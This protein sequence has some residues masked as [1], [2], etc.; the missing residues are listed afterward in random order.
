MRNVEWDT[1]DNMQHL[2]SEVFTYNKSGKLLVNNENDANSDLDKVLL[3]RVGRHI[4]T[5]SKKKIGQSHVY[6]KK[7]INS[8]GNSSFGRSSH[9]QKDS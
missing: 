5:T 9:F 4:V 7:S 1:K 6:R 8:K 2:S 3:E